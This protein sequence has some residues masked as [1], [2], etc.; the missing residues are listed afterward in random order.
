[1]LNEQQQKEEPSPMVQMQ[2]TPTKMRPTQPPKKEPKKEEPKK[3]EEVPKEEEK[4]LNPV[5]KVALKQKMLW[6][7]MQ[8]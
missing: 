3:M 2:P 4:K 6:N 1:M 7:M 5:D 8:K